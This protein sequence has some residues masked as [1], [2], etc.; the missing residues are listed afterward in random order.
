MQVALDADRILLFNRLTEPE[1]REFSAMLHAL[2]NTE[3]Y[4]PAMKQ[5]YKWLNTK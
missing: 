3:G 4:R 5:I 2:V 1:Y